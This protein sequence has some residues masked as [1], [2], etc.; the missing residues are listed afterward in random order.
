MPLLNGNAPA[1]LPADTSAA[2]LVPVLTTSLAA[3]LALEPVPLPGY[4][5]L[6]PA[7]MLMAV[8]HWTIYR[9]QLLPPTAVFAIGVG[10]DLLCG[11]PPGVTSLL[12]LLTRAAVLRGRRRFVNRSFGF[13]WAGFAVPASSVL[14]AQWAFDCVLAWRL[15]DVSDSVFRAALTIVLFPAASAVL[16]RTQQALMGPG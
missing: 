8:Y 2:R 15:F 12:L 13:V 1:N 3:L 6:T 5:V 4:A 7:F 16:G 10:Y 11:G 14:L 9:P